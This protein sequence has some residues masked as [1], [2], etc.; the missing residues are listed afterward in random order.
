MPRKKTMGLITSAADIG[1]PVPLG[2]VD[3][4]RESVGVLPQPDL[5]PHKQV[6][7]LRSQIDGLRQSL[8]DAVGGG[9]REIARQAKG[10]A[11]LYPVSTVLTVAA[12]S[13]L[14]VVAVSAVTAA[15]E[16]SRY[17][18]RLADLRE[19]YGRIRDRL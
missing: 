17:D 14:F 6:Q 1:E 12:I 15:P 19:I 2:I 11:K 8:A 18:R 5:E 4:V 10:T 3:T 7:A 13:A 16:R 9:A